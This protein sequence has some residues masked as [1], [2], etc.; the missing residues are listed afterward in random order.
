MFAAD[1]TMQNLDSGFK[2]Y[3]RVLNEVGHSRKFCIYHLY[4]VINFNVFRV[5]FVSKDT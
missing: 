3:L 1:K 4:V 2:V 5:R